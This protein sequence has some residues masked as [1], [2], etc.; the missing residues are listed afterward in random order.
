V[1]NGE[2]GETTALIKGE[3]YVSTGSVTNF[4]TIKSTRID[5][6]LLEGDVTNGSASSTAAYIAGTVDFIMAPGTVTNFGTIV[7]YSDFAS[8]SAGRGKIENFGLLKEGISILGGE[9]INKGTIESGKYAIESGS[10]Y[11]YFDTTVTN[12]GTIVGKVALF[13]TSKV[14]VEPGSSIGDAVTADGGP[15]TIDFET[16]GAAGMS[17]VSGFKTITLGNGK[18][19][20]LTLTSAN[21]AAV[22][23][24]AITV[25][26]GNSGNTVSAA[27]LLGSERIIVHA[28]GG[29]DKLTGG[30]G[31][32]AFFAGNNTVMTGNA[33]RNQFIFSAAGD[34]RV[35]DF[36]VSAGNEVVFSN[37]GFSLGSGGASGTPKA[38][39]AGLFV[40]NSDG[41]FT[42]TTQRFAYATGSGDL[43]YSASGENGTPALVSH[44]TG[45]PSL[46][47]SQLFFIT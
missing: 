8:I 9:V 34:N 14:V 3:V 40:E 21:F 18:G 47:A 2:S 30:K 1:V 45:A 22:V 27:S 5:A 10:R 37:K 32:D 38:L 44:F 11:Q 39:P 26:D 17:N 16:A 19:H 15:S 24:A 25:E 46:A 28:G 12:F 23:G 41:H 35:A 31:G 20:T 13:G 4:G 33:G 42:D 7:G 6:I 36:A 29:L 43:F